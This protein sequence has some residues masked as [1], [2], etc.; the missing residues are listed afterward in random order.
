MQ[1]ATYHLS[2]RSPP[3]H[4]IPVLCTKK[5]WNWYWK[6]LNMFF[7]CP[8]SIVVGFW[9]WLCLYSGCVPLNILFFYANTLFAYDSDVSIAIK[10]HVLTLA[11]WKQYFC[12]LISLFT[13]SCPFVSLFSAF[14][15]FYLAIRHGFPYIKYLT[16]QNVSLTYIYSTLLSDMALISGCYFHLTQASHLFSLF[17]SIC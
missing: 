15:F 4:I 3:P 12:P 16:K 2:S 5:K 13:L 17:V 1:K 6:D 9:L 14:F 8:Y 11:D 10:H 7:P